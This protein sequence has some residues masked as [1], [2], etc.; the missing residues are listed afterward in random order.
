MAKWDRR[1]NMTKIWK[2]A[3][4]VTVLAVVLSLAIVA[5]PVASPA[6]A[7]P[8]TTYYV[9]AATGN[10]GNDGSSGNPWK[11]ITHAVAT[12]PGGA[13]GDPNIISVASG[14]Y[15]VTSNN[16]TFPITFSNEYVSLIGAGAGTTTIDCENATA[17]TILGIN[18]TGITVQNFT[19]DNAQYGIEAD[20]GGFNILDN[21]FSNDTDHDIAYGVHVAI[22][23]TNLN[24]NFSFDDI[25]I[26]GNDFYITS[27]GVYIHID[28]DFDT[29]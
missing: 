16:E 27:D 1:R 26:D 12:V 28:L 18:A 13:S 7:S 11:T 20:V 14:L 6:Q 5:L 10:D 2:S 9:D 15:D 24:S 21:V 23:K 19:L 8:G 25:L 17:G 29:A 4:T 3:S 22:S